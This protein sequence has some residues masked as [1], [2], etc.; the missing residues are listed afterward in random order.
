MKVNDIVCI[1]DNL[2]HCGE[3]GKLVEIFPENNFPYGVQFAG[4]EVIYYLLEHI[5]PYKTS[6]DDWC[7]QYQPGKSKFDGKL[8]D[9]FD[10]AKEFLS[11]ISYD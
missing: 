3:I 9:N 2:P 6:K 8:M 10:I 1:G 11:R 4:G 7:I 5:E